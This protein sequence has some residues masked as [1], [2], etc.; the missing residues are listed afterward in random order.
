ALDDALSSFSLNLPGRLRVAFDA[1]S[2]TIRVGV[3]FDFTRT[4]SVPLNFSFGQG[5]PIVLE[6]GG[7]FD[8]TVGGSLKLDL[9][10]DFSSGVQ[11][12]FDPTTKLELSAL[13]EATNLNASVNIGG[14][15]AIELGPTGHPGS[16]FLKANSTP[17]DHTPGSLVI[18]LA[19]PNNDGRVTL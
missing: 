6:T 14:V 4:V 3:D 10:A 13:V 11:L 8:V 2:K 16:F 12:F 19:D 1:P 17:G 18:S 7:Q 15:T 5:L 9:G